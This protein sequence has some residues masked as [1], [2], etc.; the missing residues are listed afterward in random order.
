MCSSQRRMAAPAQRGRPARQAVERASALRRLRPAGEHSTVPCCAEVFGRAP[1]VRHVQLAAVLHAT[2]PNP[3]FPASPPHHHHPNTH[4]PLPHAA[5]PAPPPLRTPC[6]LPCTWP[7]QWAPSL[8]AAEERLRAAAVAHHP[9]QQRLQQCRP[10]CPRWAAHVPGLCM[11]AV[12]MSVLCLLLAGCCWCPPCRPLFCHATA[13]PKCKLPYPRSLPP[14]THTHPQ[15]V[16]LKSAVAQKRAAKGG[17]G[18]GQGSPAVTSTAAPEA[19]AA[20]APAAGGAE[21]LKAQALKLLAATQAGAA[22]AASVAAL[23]PPAAAAD[24]AIAPAAGGVDALRRQAAELLARL[25]QKQAAAAGGGGGAAAAA[26]AGPAPPPPQQAAVLPMSPLSPPHHTASLDLMHGPFGTSVAAGGTLAHSAQ[27]ASM[28]GLTQTFS[29][30]AALGGRGGVGDGGAPGSPR[31]SLDDLRRQA[32]ALLAAKQEKEKAA[33]A[34]A[35]PAVAPPQVLASGGGSGGQ[36]GKMW[37]S[38]DI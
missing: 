29:G 19:V 8:R 25:Q 17:S 35:A 10:S 3:F 5:A 22:D 24:A 30:P 18:G 11:P 20:A 2:V 21:D 6:P 36:G 12:T 14:P 15:L 27:A 9:L 1:G 23:L 32:M 16:Q 4:A 13:A 7:P 28:G 37:T 31:T 26:A 34:A 33:A 38:M